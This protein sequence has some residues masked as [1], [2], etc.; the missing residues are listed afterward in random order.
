MMCG[1][2]FAAALDSMAGLE[3]LGNWQA[4]V[5][6]LPS[7]NGPVQASVRQL[8]FT[9]RRSTDQY[10]EHY[11]AV[12]VIVPSK[13]L[14]WLG[15]SSDQQIFEKRTVTRQ[16]FVFESS[17][18]GV[19]ANRGDVLRF[20]VSDKELT[21]NDSS[22][23]IDS[24]L[25]EKLSH[26]ETQR[27]DLTA[28]PF[29]IE[30]ILGAFPFTEQPSAI[31]EAAPVITKIDVDGDSFTIELA[32]GKDNAVTATITFNGSFKPVKATLRGNQVFPK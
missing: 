4:S 1:I 28:I 3:T 6:T 27:F 11:D 15:E 22:K 19:S 30:N 17:I 31:G 18:V 16:F 2:F 20:Y 24:I 5:I 10:L 7:N 32:G 25:H 9:W 29:G 23:E 21:T 13:K 14:Y 26:L 8:A 12:A